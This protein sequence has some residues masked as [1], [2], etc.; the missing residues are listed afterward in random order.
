MDNKMNM[1]GRIDGSGDA[2]LQEILDAAG[3]LAYLAGT[4]ANDDAELSANLSFISRNL[5]SLALERS[6]SFAAPAARPE[7]KPRTEKKPA[8]ASQETKPLPPEK[9]RPRFR[10]GDDMI[11]PVPLPEPEEKPEKH[12]L[13]FSYEISPEKRAEIRDQF[14]ELNSI[15]PDTKFDFSRQLPRNDRLY[16]KFEKLA[17]EFQAG[18]GKI[19]GKTVLSVETAEILNFEGVQ[20]WESEDSIPEIAERFF[21]GGYDNRRHAPGFRLKRL[22]QKYGA[23]EWGKFAALPA[24]LSDSGEEKLLLIIP[25]G[26]NEPG[27]SR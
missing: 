12:L 21:A 22:F 13:S 10:P 11:T 3:K 18:G 16:D 23:G 7:E 20:V 5:T 15:F 17:R 25:C 14:R 8:P 26:N 2:R 19:A 24:A 1:A 27:D 6:R 4:F 9:P